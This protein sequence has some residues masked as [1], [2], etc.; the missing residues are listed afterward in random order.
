MCILIMVL[1]NS[2]FWLLNWMEKK[3]D[4]IYVLF[5]CSTMSP[6]LV[7]KLTH[8]ENNRACR[9]LGPWCSVSSAAACRDTDQQGGT[10][11]STRLSRPHHQSQ[12]IHVH[13]FTLAYNDTL[14]THVAASLSTHTL[15]AYQNDLCW[16]S[17]W[18]RLCCCD[19]ISWRLFRRRTERV[20]TSFPVVLLV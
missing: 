2:K 14:V 1:G 11:Q 12:S 17:W 4:L 8:D 15:F 13:I 6:T 5:V 20:T 3:S 10:D 7:M 16:W 18:A 9:P 19:D